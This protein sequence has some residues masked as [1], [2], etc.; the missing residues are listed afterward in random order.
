MLRTRNLITS[1]N[2]VP[3][4]WIYEFYL[5]LFGELN[6][7]NIT[8]LSIFNPNDKRPSFNLYWTGIEKGYMWKDFSVGKGGNAIELVKELKKVDYQSACIIII[9]DFNKYTLNNKYVSDTLI[10]EKV[11]FKL[12][13]FKL[14]KWNSFDKD[15]WTSYGFN[16]KML[17]YYN[18]F[19]LSEYTLERTDGR[20][21][22]IVNTNI[23]GFFN[24]KK[25]LY[26]I[27]QPL[28][29]EYKFC[30]IEQYIQGLDQLTYKK[31][32]LVITSS[33]KDGIALRSLKFNNIEFVAPSGE[34]VLLPEDFIKT[35]KE[36]YKGICTLFDNDEA[37]IIAMRKYK[38]AFNLPGFIFKYEKDIADACKVYGQK[39]VCNLITQ[40]LFNTLK[41]Y[42]NE[43][44]ICSNR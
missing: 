23:Y 3:S 44:N 26:K 22:N 27:Y 13:S 7:Q 43:N 16:S 19:P 34:S 2:D 8:K 9:N 41:L 29:R 1:I 17:E 5:S 14:R 11:T 30:M 38:E 42:K 32:Y 18:I 33:M 36:K 15:Y 4:N 20:T 39:D 31:D 40:P 35:A 37:G 12:K 24:K 10:N 6:G 21:V 28:N 25:K